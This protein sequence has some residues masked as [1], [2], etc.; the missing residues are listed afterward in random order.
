MSAG[1][2]TVGARRSAARRIL[3]AWMGICALF[4]GPVAQ[5]EKDGSIE[6]RSAYT[7]IDDGV[8]YLNGRVDLLLS[9]D[10]QNALENGVALNIELQIEVSQR[11]RY[12]WDKTVASLRQ[13]YQ[14]TYHALT[15]R[16]VLSNLNSGE[17]ESF[18][19][20]D[21]ALVRLGDIQRLPVI[22]EALLDAETRY[23]GNLRVQMDIREMSGPLRVLTL[24]WGDWRVTS[25]WYRWPVQR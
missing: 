10:A 20:L 9:K 7:A 25:E 6:I 12:V 1:S 2:D 15:G 11:R 17:R 22:D 18:S 14:L 13:R 16:Y 24:F 8:Y 21:N 4:S 19:S 23:D 3:V 5:A